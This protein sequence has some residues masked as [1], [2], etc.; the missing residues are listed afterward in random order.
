MA[1]NK[2]KKNRDLKRN[3]NVGYFWNKNPL[4]GYFMRE[5]IKRITNEY[6][7][8]TKLGL[9]KNYVKVN[10]KQLEKIESILGHKINDLYMLIDRNSK[11][12]R[13]VCKVLDIDY[14]N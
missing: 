10:K 6:T 3:N 1:K 7:Y 14:N 5:Y 12:G 9:F 2:V 4:K 13:E 11:H 8:D